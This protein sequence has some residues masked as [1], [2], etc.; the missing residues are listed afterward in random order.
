MPEGMLLKEKRK[1]L[2]KLV[3]CEINSR[4]ISWHITL[5]PDCKSSTVK[6]LFELFLNTVIFSQLKNVA[7]VKLT[8]FVSE[9]FS[10]LQTTL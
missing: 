8:S 3:M 7:E 9:F 5:T 4:F 10:Q 6:I 2:T 1:K